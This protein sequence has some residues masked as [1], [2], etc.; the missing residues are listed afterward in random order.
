MKVCIL[1][2][3]KISEMDL[4]FNAKYYVQYVARLLT[5]AE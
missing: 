4:K 3:R 5:H 1:Q 2:A